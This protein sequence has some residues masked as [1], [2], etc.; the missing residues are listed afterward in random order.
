[1][2]FL[3]RFSYFGY[4]LKNTPSVLGWKL[5]KR[6]KNTSRFRG[7]RHIDLEL[8]NST[9]K[10]YINK[11]EAFA[12]IRFGAVELSCLNNHEKIELGLKRKYKYL[13]KYSMKN[14]AGFYPVDDE[15]LKEYGDY[16]LPLLAETDL[17][18][19]SGVHL[20]DY[21]AKYYTKNAKYILYEGM[22]PLRGDWIQNLS[23][24][25]V[26]VISPFVDDIEH[27]YAKKDL[28]FPKG[29]LP[30]F[31]LKL[32]QA[33]LTLGDQEGDQPTFFDGLEKM[34]DTIKTID[35]DIAL[36]GAGA[37]GSLLCLEI[38][39]MGKMA[40]QTGGATQTMFGII[41]KRWEN[42][43][44]VSKYVNEYWIKP[45]LKPKGFTKVEKGAYW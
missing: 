18:G 35:F 7:V 39:K 16:F 13:V 30:T 45:S 38:K 31:E 9:L 8:T 22:E 32:L 25:K 1:M 36:V 37:Y 41:G 4:F 42:R 27:Q 2:K 40:I 26:L 29:F 17:L 6:K 44:H 15:H 20:E 10:E 5:F 24:K 19:I 3:R 28:I 14:N 23:G 12:A 43:P 34:I 21:F 33:P 11:G